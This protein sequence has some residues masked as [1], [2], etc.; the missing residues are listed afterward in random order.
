[1]A[2]STIKPGGGGDYTTLAAWWTAEFGSLEAPWAEC[3]TGGDLGMLDMD[4]ITDALGFTPTADDYIRVYPGT[5]QQHTGRSGTGCYINVTSSGGIGITNNV[6]DYTR[7]EG[8]RV[9]LQIA[10]NGISM[11][12]S[13]YGTIKDNLI[14]NPSYVGGSVVGLSSS[15][16]TVSET[17]VK[18]YNNFLYC[19]PISGAVTGSKGLSLYATASGGDMSYDLDVYNNT[20][21]G[22]YTAVGTFEGIILKGTGDPNLNANIKNNIGVN[23]VGPVCARTNYGA[24]S[25]TIVASNNL[26]DDGT[27]ASVFS[28]T[29]DQGS[30]LPEAQVKNPSSAWLLKYK[31]DALGNGTPLVDVTTDAFGNARHATT[32]DIGANEWLGVKTLVK[33]GVLIKEGVDIV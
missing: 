3:Y 22:F 18:I 17:G 1:M 15:A 20:V 8:I 4:S 33:E 2:V 7:L 11:F 16:L 6:I 14:E 21:Y 32:P 24:T 10:G 27:F 12:S 19:N 5:D 30:K 25:G 26:D 9:E 23:T 28:S 31:A 13:S 29:S